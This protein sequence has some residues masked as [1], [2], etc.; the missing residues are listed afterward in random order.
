VRFSDVIVY[1]TLAVWTASGGVFADRE[2]PRGSAVLAQGQRVPPPPPSGEAPRT[3]DGK[4]DLSGV[5]LRLNVVEPGQPEMLPSAAALYDERRQNGLRDMPSARCLPMGVSLVGPIVTKFVQT[6]AVL[7]AIQEGAGTGA[8][9]VFLDGR[10]HPLDLQ[11]MWRGHSIGTW[12]GDTLVVDTVGFNDLSWIDATGLPRS[13]E[14]HVIERIRRVDFG[15]LEIET[16]IDD[17][18]RFV[19]TW[20]RRSTSMLAPEEEV[21]EFVCN[22]NNQYQPPPVGK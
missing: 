22:E 5:W 7:I 12:E 20:T 8:L 19:R 10:D 17:P 13:E 21:Q 6:A 4:P 18:G 2:G 15:H 16:T 1:L 11:P 14:L 3:I 9:Q